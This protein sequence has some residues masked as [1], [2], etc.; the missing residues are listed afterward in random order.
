MSAPFNDIF[1]CTIGG[2]D[3]ML[4]AYSKSATGVYGD[5]GKRMGTKVSFKCKGEIWADDADDL[6][7]AMAAFRTSAEAD[8]ADFTITAHGNPREQILAADC[9][10]GPLV[11]YDY[12]DEQ[13]HNCQSVTVTVSAT[14]GAEGE[15]EGIFSITY[16]TKTA[17]NLEGLKT[18]TISGKIVTD[19]TPEA[20]T[21]FLEGHGST[22]ALKPTR[23]AG[24]QQTYDYDCNEADTECSFTVTQT[25]LKSA[26]PNDVAGDGAPVVD[27][28]YTF[29]SEEDNHNRRIERH[30]YSY[31]GTGAASRIEAIHNTLHNGGTLLR[32]SITSTQHKTQS[33]T[34]NFDV[35]ASQDDSDILELTESI[36]HAVG[37]LLRAITYPGTTPLI[38]KTDKGAYRYSQQGRAVGLVRHPHP[39]AYAF[40]ADNLSDKK[41]DLSQ[42]SDQ[43]FETSWSFAF[44]FAAEQDITLPHARADVT[45]FYD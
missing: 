29:S 25:E 5:D 12:G 9:I 2:S 32:A 45:T 3:F 20:S 4:T 10:E 42:N 30:S 27:G 17:V 11:S 40:D 13:G 41:V 37:P 36:S 34:G 33:A 43:E 23:P 18:I 39:P 8:E 35:L 44:I 7:D 31:T 38:V 1:S 24:W 19:G 14:V 26:Y 16:S 21:V 22:E 15:E 6:V 28:E